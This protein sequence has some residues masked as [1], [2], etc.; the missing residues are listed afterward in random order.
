MCENNAQSEQPNV[1]QQLYNIFY[2]DPEALQGERIESS[3]SFL[4]NADPACVAQ[5]VLARP[6]RR[7]IRVSLTSLTAADAARLCA[8]LDAAF[9]PLTDVQKFTFSRAFRLEVGAPG[10]SCPAWA[11]RVLPHGGVLIRVGA[12]VYGVEAL[13]IAQL[14]VGRGEVLEALTPL[15]E[16]TPDEVRGV[17][18]VIH[19]GGD[20]IR[21][22]RSLP[23]ALSPVGQT[24]VFAPVAA[25]MLQRA[26]LLRKA[27]ALAPR[28][29]SDCLVLRVFENRT[30]VHLLGRADDDSQVLSE[31]Y[32]F[33]LGDDT[34]EAAVVP[35]E[36]LQPT[37][38]AL[39][40]YAHA[41]VAARH[42]PMIAA[43]ERSGPVGAAL[44]R[45]IK[46]G[47]A[48]EVASKMLDFPAFFGPQPDVP[49][50]HRDARPAY[51]EH[52]ADAGTN[53]LALSFDFDGLTSIATLAYK[54][55]VKVDAA[56]AKTGGVTWRYV[57]SDGETSAAFEAGSAEFNEALR[58]AQDAVMQEAAE[59]SDKPS[60]RPTAAEQAAALED[61]TYSLT[62]LVKVDI[63]P[64]AAHKLAL[65]LSA[66][67][68]CFD[69]IAMPAYGLV[70]SYSEGDALDGNA[71][72][73][74]VS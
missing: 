69:S 74:V 54:L 12:Q 36:K 8:V 20:G 66:K 24:L 14:D 59:L 29:A 51:W 68:A 39:T 55:M 61:C 25:V 62:V 34:A 57:L 10:G 50:G 65:K 31:E 2:S 45:G 1:K 53:I 32:G 73:F 7:F 4:E 3:L 22:S 11:P 13:P 64:G 63:A 27:G 48:S 33:W 17:L 30:F 15:F 26:G 6:A 9:A 72:S 60:K 67:D 23:E 44:V 41:L 43:F 35:G 42:Q 71:S 16:D 49:A 21:W 56:V 19:H 5:V 70:Q 40:D 58:E 18:S 52:L 28:P 37:Y 47:H 46:V 38:E